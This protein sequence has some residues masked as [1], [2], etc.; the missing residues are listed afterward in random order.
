MV[1]SR[2]P[3]APSA[4]QTEAQS[5]ARAPAPAPSTPAEPAKAGVNPWKT[6]GK[7]TVAAA[8][9]STAPPAAAHTEG[10]GKWIRMAVD[11]KHKQPAGHSGYRAGT[12]SE[13]DEAAGGAGRARMGRTGRSSRRGGGRDKQR[14]RSTASTSTSSTP[15]STRADGGERAKPTA[16]TTS[17]H[18]KPAAGTN[19]ADTGVRGQ[20]ARGKGHRNGAGGAGAGAAG[21]HHRPGGNRRLLLGRGQGHGPRHGGARHYGAGAG[22]AS[23]D[24][25]TAY[26]TA[27]PC[28]PGYPA[29]AADPA[30]ADADTIK[31]YLRAQIEYYFSIENLCRDIYLRSHMDDEGYVAIDVLAAFNRIKNLAQPTSMILES[32][33]SSECVEVKGQLIRKRDDWKTWLLP[34]KMKIATP[35]T[36]TA[37]S[38]AQPTA[39]A[40]EHSQTTVQPSS[41]NDSSTVE[42][43]SSKTENEAGWTVKTNRRPRR[44]PPRDP[45]TQQQ[46]QQQRTNGT[47]TSPANGQQHQK[48]RQVDDEHVFTFDD[49][50][51]WPEQASGRVQRYEASSDEEGE[52][53]TT[54]ATA[55]A[56]AAAKDVP[57]GGSY[58]ERR[59]HHEKNEQ[60]H[61]DALLV[62]DSDYEDGYDDEDYSSYKYNPHY[63]YYLEGDWGDDEELDDDT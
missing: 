22:D 14:A 20:S 47:A 45:S 17:Q 55:A 12:S 59:K 7:P 28:V 48:H 11:I 30:S 33:S 6:T 54:A 8:P 19:H 1:D 21:G 41:E 37:A 16:S 34:E 31:H 29:V 5:A 3:S 61:L 50:A 46:Q 27:Y 49:D 51:A 32:L 52:G 44:V 25:A 53:N 39:T 4:D 35:I 42:P 57:N 43:S 10:K 56:A 2:L 18:A 40:T 60:D 13:K 62:G 36:S 23:G 58:Q 24:I 63:D 26:G 38:P 15:R 9:E